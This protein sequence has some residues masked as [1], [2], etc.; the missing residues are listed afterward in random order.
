[1]ALCLFKTF[2]AGPITSVAIAYVIG[3]TAAI[4]AL[5]D[6]PADSVAAPPPARPPR[7]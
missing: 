2:Q 6:T 1:M 7:A 3:T 5:N 4:S